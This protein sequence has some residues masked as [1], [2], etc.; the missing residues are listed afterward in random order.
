MLSHLPF[1][2]IVAHRLPLCRPV[3]RR[4]YINQSVL[5]QYFP[6][7]LQW[8]D[9]R[10]TRDFVSVLS[11][12]VDSSLVLVIP[13]FAPSLHKY[14]KY[15]TQHQQHMA[16]TTTDLFKDKYYVVRVVFRTTSFRAH[17]AT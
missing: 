5:R 6:E 17:F 8:Q 10:K 16:C 13:V 1:I 14:P 15:N 9:G 4:D 12:T 11:E 2:G 3:A 7:W